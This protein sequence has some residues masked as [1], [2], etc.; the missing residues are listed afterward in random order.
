M[1]TSEICAQGPEVS[2]G[3]VWCCMVLCPPQR[4]HLQRPWHTVRP[5][6]ILAPFG[7]GATELQGAGNVLQLCCNCVVSVLSDAICY[8]AASAGF[9]V[10][11]PL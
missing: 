11:V 1:S 6:P 8:L 3:V 9:I 10:A 5:R 4:Q 2:C 7:A